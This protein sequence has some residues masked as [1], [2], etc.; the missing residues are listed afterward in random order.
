[1]AGLHT[2]KPETAETLRAFTHQLLRG[3]SSLTVTERR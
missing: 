1:M 2:F 3:A